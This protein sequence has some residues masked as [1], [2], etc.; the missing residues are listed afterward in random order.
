MRELGFSKVQVKFENEGLNLIN[1][2]N[3]YIIIGRNVHNNEGG[4]TWQFLAC[5]RT[6]YNH[7]K[8]QFWKDVHK[9][10]EDLHLLW[11]VFG[12]LN[13]IT[14]EYDKLGAK[15]FWKKRLYLKLVMEFLGAINLGFIGRRF[16]WVNNHAGEGLIKQRLDRAFADKEWL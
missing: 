12:D 2:W 8:N 13:E 11:I 16:T 1:V 6:P 15:S 10:I 5:H 9:L 7:E 14:K 3:T 4:C